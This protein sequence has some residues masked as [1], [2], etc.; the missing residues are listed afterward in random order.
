MKNTLQWFGWLSIGIW[1]ATAC[2]TVQP[3]ATTSTEIDVSATAYETYVDDSVYALIEQRK[4]EVPAWVTPE[5]EYHPE[6][7]RYFQLINTTLRVAFDW[8]TQRMPGEATL[9]LNP[10]FYPQDSVVLDAKGFD[11]HQVARLSLSDTIALSYRYDSL[12]LAIQLDQTF[13]KA[14]TFQLFVRYTAKPTELPKGGSAAITSEQGLYFINPDGNNPFKPQQIWT[15]GETEASSCWFPTFD[16][17]NVKTRQEL[18]ITVDTA[19]TTV[20]NGKLVSQQ[21]NPDGTRTDYWKMDQPHAPYLFAMAVGKFAKIEDTWQGKPVNYYVEPEYAKY[22]KQIF[23]NTPEMLSFFSKKLD[24]PY[25]W[26][27]YDQVVVRDFVSGAMENTT[28]SIFMEDLQVDDR[29]LIDDHWDGIIAHELFH[30]WFGN[31]VTC[32]SWANLPLNESFA[33]YAEYLWTEHKYGRDAADLAWKENFDQY[34]AEAETKQVPLI[35]YRYLDKELMFDS[36]S[37]AKGSLILNLLRNYVG[38]DAFFKALNVYLTKHAY[39]T[40]E[41]HDLRQAFEEV[42]GQDWNWFFD[43]WFLASGHPNLYVKDEYEEGTL[44]VMVQQKQDERFTPIYRLPVSID[45]WHGEQKKRYEVVVN[46]A[47]QVFVFPMDTAPDLVLFDAE[48]LL[49]GIVDHLK[50]T[51]AFIIQYQ[52]SNRI[53][54]KLDALQQ[55]STGMDEPEILP[56]MLAALSHPEPAIR[57]FVAEAF[58]NYQGSQQEQLIGLLKS[59]ATTDESSLVRGTALNTLSSLGEFPALLRKALSDSSCVVNAYA[60]FNLAEL[61]GEQLLP[62]VE[63]LENEENLNI[64]STVADFYSYY[65]I[66]GKYEW[67]TTAIAKSQASVKPLF[68]NYLGSYLM[69]QPTEVQQKGITQLEGYAATHPNRNVRVAAFQ[70]LSLL[71]NVEGVNALLEKLKENEKDQEVKNYFQMLGN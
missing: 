13:T 71:S 57:E 42:T 61:E 38:D 41:V 63:Q 10:F 19:F 21:E 24:Y 16:A 7:T 40:A 4:N 51:Q 15:Q 39:G 37:Y 3:T 66:S 6:A 49:P 5:G 58:E 56:I 35:R 43:Q 27:K 46:Q 45:V 22:A 28:V 34:L 55:L 33:T 26:H 25:P 17:P 52:E 14:D 8:E 23:G 9:V 1:L 50:S 31:L 47:S 54:A 44:R 69:Q 18:Y 53:L 11:I 2:K 48:T 70:A 59:M 20:S 30:H 12:T 67:F 68:L 64:K 62:T 60:L 36:H 32:E 65:S 29:Y